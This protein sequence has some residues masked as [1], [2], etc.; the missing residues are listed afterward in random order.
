M[1]MNAKIY[2]ALLAVCCISPAAFAQNLNP[3]VQVTNDYTSDMGYVTK[4]VTEFSIPDTVLHFDYNFDYSVFDN[5]YRGAYEFRP[6]AV[7]LTPAPSPSEARRLYLRA[8]AGYTLH[9]ELYV[10]YTPE[11]EGRVN[12]TAYQDFSGYAGRYWKDGN[13]FMPV[14]GSLYPG[15]DLSEK[16]GIRGGWAHPAFDLHWDVGYRGLYNA[17]D[18]RRSLYHSGIATV[19]VNSH[20]PEAGSLNYDFTLNALFG[21]D[22]ITHFL[23]YATQREGSVRI[24]G[25]IGPFI[26]HAFSVVLDVRAEQYFYGGAVRRNPGL[27]GATPKVVLR[28]GK[29][30]LDAGVSLDLASR[31]GIHPDVRLSAD[32]FGGAAN[33]FAG[34]K[35]GL[36]R[37]S[38]SGFKQQLHRFTPA[39]TDDFAA[40][41]DE[42]INLY[43]GIQG[44]LFPHFSYRLQGGFADYGNAPLVSVSTVGGGA[45]NPFQLWPSIAYTNYRTPYADLKLAYA[46]ARLTADG[47]FHFRYTDL[48]ASDQVLD[49]PIF[50]GDARVMYNWLQRIYAGVSCSFATPRVYG[51]ETYAVAMPYWVDLGVMAEYKIDR[52]WSVW[53]RG[54]NLLNMAIQPIPLYVEQ[55]I[56]FTAGF[57]LNL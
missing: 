15:Y 28:I 56:N 3:Q 11:L 34:V 32:L 27:I 19:R 21:V 45:L 20:Q 46:G 8:G 41:T 52:R 10:L 14:E 24:N 49:L 6:Y 22:Q 35:G 31:L 1:T 7:R 16:A 39:Y 55:G 51:Y 25:T 2:S 40:V 18:N 4:P 50:S 26:G 13:D 38:Y 30:N 53:A 23:D 36:S 47:D 29:F 48:Q 9:P 44:N 37:N 43:A 57:C 17:D 33:I 42:K 54:G 5:P 12:L